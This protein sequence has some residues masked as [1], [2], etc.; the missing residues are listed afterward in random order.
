MH[1]HVVRTETL[2]V[3]WKSCQGQPQCSL[4]CLPGSRL[5]LDPQR[6]ES[7]TDLTQTLT[8]TAG[9]LGRLRFNFD[10]PRTVQEQVGQA[11][12]LLT[13]RRPPLSNR[14]GLESMHLS[15]NTNM[16]RRKSLPVTDPPTGSD[17]FPEHKNFRNLVR[18]CDRS[19]RVSLVSMQGRGQTDVMMC[20]LRSQS[21]SCVSESC[22]GY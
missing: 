10:K 6:I 12:C 20:V 17:L 8:L 15:V 5:T 1:V 3:G 11:F 21:R 16:N 7:E 2:R 13:G 4:S 18:L 14:A 22:C 19:K 9:W